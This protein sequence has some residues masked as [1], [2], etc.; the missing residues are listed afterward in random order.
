MNLFV[1]FSSK[2]RRKRIFFCKE[3][4]K[5]N[6]LFILILRETGSV[7]LLNTQYTIFNVCWKKQSYSN[8][9]GV[10]DSTNN[11]NEFK[12]EIIIYSIS[13]KSGAISLEKN[14]STGNSNH[15]LKKKLGVYPSRKLLGWKCA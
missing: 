9:R 4:L 8:E 12:R 11:N 5:G 6:A 14:L 1:Q 10:V 2:G 3:C 15:I 13:G 7:F